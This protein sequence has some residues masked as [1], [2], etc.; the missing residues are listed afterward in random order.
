MI[1]AVGYNRGHLLGIEDV[2]DF[3]AIRAVF[4]FQVATNPV[5]R[6]FVTSSG[7]P[8][9]PADWSELTFLPIQAFK[10]A[11]VRSGDWEEEA[12]FLSSGTGNME[13]SR[14]FIRSMDNYLARTEDVFNQLVSRV[15]QVRHIVFMPFYQA[16]PQS[17]LLKMLKYFIHRSADDGSRFVSSEKELDDVLSEGMEHTVLWTVTFGLVDYV[18]KSKVDDLRDLTIIETG[19]FKGRKKTFTREEVHQMARQRWS[20]VRIL[21]EYGMCELQSQAYWSRDHFRTPPGLLC[22][23]SEVDDPFRLRLKSHR[24]QLNFID[25]ANIDT[26]SFIATQ[27]F[28]PVQNCRSFDVEGRLQ[29]SDLRGCNLMYQ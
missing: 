22:L 21:S 26:C 19:G 8:V 25:L 7:R 12:I 6:Q 5:F 29:A 14:H 15:D 4:Q 16:N 17:S 28:G 10:W 2:A 24:G 1:K 13:R 18:E 3:D 11:E 27:D 20:S 9:D 23:A